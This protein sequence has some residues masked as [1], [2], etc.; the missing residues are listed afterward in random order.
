MNTGRKL[1]FTE[2]LSYG[3]ADFSDDKEAATVIAE[4]E[5]RKAKSMN[6]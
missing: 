4:L 3:L 6:K 2:K 5:S 1:K